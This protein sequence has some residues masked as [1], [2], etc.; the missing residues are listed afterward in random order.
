[1]WPVMTNKK[2]TQLTKHFLPYLDFSPDTLKICIILVH[3]HTLWWSGGFQ[4]SRCR[5][6]QH[7]VLCCQG[8]W[9]CAGGHLCAKRG[10]TG[11]S[12]IFLGG[13]SYQPVSSVPSGCWWSW[14]WSWGENKRGVCC[15]RQLLKAES[16]KQVTH[17][18]PAGSKGHILL[19]SANMTPFF[20]S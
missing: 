17:L 15:K 2:K 18:V 11:W 3:T 9:R 13:Q 1:M 16:W 5:N 6:W 14:S 19:A 8:R 20:T 12:G 7:I 10:E 4:C